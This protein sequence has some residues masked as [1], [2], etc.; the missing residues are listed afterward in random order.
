MKGMLTSTIWVAPEFRE[1][2]HDP[3]TPKPRNRE[4]QNN[5]TYYI[6]ATISFLHTFVRHIAGRRVYKMLQVCNSVFL[7]NRN[8]SQVLPV[9][10]LQ[11]TTCVHKDYMKTLYM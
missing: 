2:H 3:R 9:C 4:K 1:E 7:S 10:A 11:A 6:G 8:L 5:P